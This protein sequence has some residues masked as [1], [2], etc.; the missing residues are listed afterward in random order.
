MVSLCAQALWLEPRPCQIGELRQIVPASAET[1]VSRGKDESPLDQAAV[2]SGTHTL[3]LL[4]I[5]PI[6]E[7]A[8]SRSIH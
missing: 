5:T 7:S 2:F 8:F 1:Q 4:P 6:F 3:T